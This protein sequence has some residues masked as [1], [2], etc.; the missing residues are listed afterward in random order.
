MTGFSRLPPLVR[1]RGAAWVARLVLAA[2]LVPVASAVA[3]AAT[4]LQ[5]EAATGL[6]GFHRDDLQRYLAVHMA[7]AG[8][9]EWRFEPAEDNGSPGNRVEWNFKLNPYAGG[10]V[11]NFART[12]GYERQLGLHR[13]I[14]I[15]ARLYLNG[16]YQTLVEAQ[17]IIHGGPDDP[18][19]AAAIASATQT[20]LGPS[21][22]YRAIDLGPRRGHM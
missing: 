19:L 17:A 20:L 1:F 12:S 22:A 2:T 9:G 5:V 15:E 21:G 16:E 7:E 8:L 4:T 13:P 10:E 11:R 6:P 18:A 14:T 3:A